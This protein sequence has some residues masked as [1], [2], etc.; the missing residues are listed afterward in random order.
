MGSFMIFN[1]SST[2]QCPNN[3]SEY[4]NREYKTVFY[5]VTHSLNF[6]EGNH[7]LTPGKLSY[8]FISRAKNALVQSVLILR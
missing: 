8:A 7:L 5:S 4:A 6:N 2:S 3:D 1:R